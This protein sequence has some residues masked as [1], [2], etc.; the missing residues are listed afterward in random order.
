MIFLRAQ[1]VPDIYQTGKRLD[2]RR[3]AGYRASSPMMLEPLQECLTILE[4]RQSDPELAQ[5]LRSILERP[6]WLKAWISRIRG[7]RRK[8][9]VR[10][11]RFRRAG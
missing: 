3:V 2:L 8:W 5:A 7:I 9:I 4:E 1:G 6:D 11:R 10:L